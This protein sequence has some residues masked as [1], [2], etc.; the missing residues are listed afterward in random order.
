MRIDCFQVE[1]QDHMTSEWRA[2]GCFRPVFQWKQ[3]W[4]RVL[5]CLWKRAHPGIVGD[6]QVALLIVKSDAHK[7]AR[8]VL[9]Y[10]RPHAIRIVRIEREGSRLAKFVVWQNGHWLEE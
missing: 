8:Q 2:C 5:G 7:Y 3:K 4:H 6:P 9:L 10:Q 1:V